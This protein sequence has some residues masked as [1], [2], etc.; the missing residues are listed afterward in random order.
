MMQLM[1]NKLMEYIEAYRKFLY[2]LKVLRQ[3]NIDLGK[4]HLFSGN[5]KDACLRFWFI[6]NFFAK[7]DQENRYWYA[8][9]LVMNKNYKKAI[10]LLDGN[11]FDT[12]DLKNYLSRMN[13]ISKIPEDIT[14]E[15]NRIT[16]NYRE[17]RYLF[18]ESNLYSIF[19]EVASNY[20]PS[21]KP[22]EK[23]ETFNVLEIGSHHLWMVEFASYLPSNHSIDTLNFRDEGI[24]EIIAYNNEKKLYR[25]II[26]CEA[27]HFPKLPVKYDIIICFDG[28]SQTSDLQEL[29]KQM[30]LLLSD[31]GILAMVL[32]KGNLVK[33]DPSSNNF[34]YNQ[35][36]INENLK[37][38]NFESSSVLSFVMEQ[39]REYYIVI[40]Q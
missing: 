29:F 30:K 8:W 11:E 7:N 38:A 20:I 21:F 6:D 22:N 35:S 34:V 19:L 16:E 32:P 4:F 23:Y 3:A 39:K 31:S 1:H 15:Y 18:K 5:I 10:K 33:L 14:K 25:N 13:S 28:F 27:L 2:H 12:I 24:N 9:A 37:L 26:G 36:F 40:G 17:Q